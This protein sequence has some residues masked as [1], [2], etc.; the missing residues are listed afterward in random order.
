MFLSGFI[1]FHCLLKWRDNFCNFVAP[2]IITVCFSYL[3]RNMYGIGAVVQISD[4]YNNQAL[5][6]GLAD[7]CLGIM[8]ARLN[9]YIQINYK[10]WKHI[11]LLGVLGFLFV[12]LFSLKYGDTTRDFLYV[13]VLTVSVA[14]A[15]LPSESK[16]Y[17]C[18]FI[19]KWSSLTLCMYLVHDAFRTFI[20]PTYLGFPSTLGMK[21][22]YLFL[23]MVVVTLFAL[24]FEI[25]IK[26]TLRKIKTFMN[27][28]RLSV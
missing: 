19:Q 27:K 16:I 17:Q 22:A 10:D 12:I 15:F 20:F 3:F 26:W 23:Y 28:N 14:I 1:I 18:K 8:A 2:L 24:V 6:R 21:F 7:M 4:L 25:F 5:M 11:R 13:M 9:T